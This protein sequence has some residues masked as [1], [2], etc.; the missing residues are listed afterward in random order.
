MEGVVIDR[1]KI[2]QQ[3]IKTII[4]L[5]AGASFG[6]EYA[7]PPLINNFFEKANELGIN[8]KRE[9]NRLWKFLKDNF[10]LDLRQILSEE[11]NGYVNI[12]QIYSLTSA[13]GDDDI[14]TL[15]ERY[16]YQTI[17]K[18]TNIYKNKSCSYHDCIIKYLRPI[19][20]ISF[21][22]DL[23]IDKSLA[24]NYKNWENSQLREFRKVYDGKSFIESKEFIKSYKENKKERFPL[25]FKLHGSL[26][27]YYDVILFERTRARERWT[28]IK[29]DYIV[30]LR[31]A[32]DTQ[33]I[34]KSRPLRD[35]APSTLMTSPGLHDTQRADLK[36]DLIPPIYNKIPQDWDEILQELRTANKIVFIGY[37]LPD[38]D[39][40]AIRLFRRAYQKHRNKNDLIVE[41]VNPDNKKNVVSKLK[42]IY[43]ASNVIKV[44]N[45][46]KEYAEKL[47]R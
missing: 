24:T 46:I 4:I 39:L 37:S 5:G 2:T 9:F 30:P 21:N 15:L 27:R 12:E 40:W 1:I 23:I 44:A 45:T 3:D 13:L 32:F 28:E 14:Q 17:T 6:S 36:L 31:Y 18:T 16:L 35:Y 41:V 47:A 33:R 42:S 8:K 10:G 38:I 43:Y 29:T 20:I 7:S 22:Y 11:K 34:Y 19:A 25:L 26:N